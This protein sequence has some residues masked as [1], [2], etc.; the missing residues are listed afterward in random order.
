MQPELRTKGVRAK[1]HSGTLLV[2]TI[3]NDVAN[4]RCPVAASG[5]KLQAGQGTE[6]FYQVLAHSSL[7]DLHAA[8]QQ[9]PG[10][11]SFLSTLV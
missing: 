9:E 10:S 4:I 7:Y 8:H 5:Q 3:Q 11:G 1:T 2:H 6:H